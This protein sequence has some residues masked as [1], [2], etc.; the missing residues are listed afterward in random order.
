M[1][2][3]EYPNRVV[4]AVKVRSWELNPGEFPWAADPLHGTEGVWYLREDIDR[5]YV[6][7]EPCDKAEPYR[8]LYDLVPV[9][10]AKPQCLHTHRWLIRYWDC[11]VY[12]PTTASM[13]ITLD[14]HWQEGGPP[15]WS[16]NGNGCSVYGLPLDLTSSSGR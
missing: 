5:D 8:W 7:V 12:M 14:E 16:F 2:L 3:V 13:R 1:S 4:L 6:K 9:P 15:V 11:D 10:Q